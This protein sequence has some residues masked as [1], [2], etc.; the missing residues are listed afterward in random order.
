M[1]RPLYLFYILGCNYQSNPTRLGLLLLFYIGRAWTYTRIPVSLITSQL[2]PLSFLQ[3]IYYCR[4]QLWASQV[5]TKSWEDIPRKQYGIQNGDVKTVAG[6]AID[7]CKWM[8]YMN[9]PVTFN[10]QENVCILWKFVFLRWFKELKQLISYNHKRIVHHV[11][12]QALGSENLMDEVLPNFLIPWLWMYARKRERGIILKSFYKV[13]VHIETLTRSQDCTLPPP[14]SF[15]IHIQRY[16][17][18]VCIYTYRY[19]HIETPIYAYRH[20]HIEIPTCIY[21]YLYTHTDI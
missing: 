21:T 5:S 4:E 10:N 18:C 1:D 14:D 17:I 7:R 3:P 6:K 9:M 15:N 19:I 2:L 12:R 13:S 8:L 16:H 11:S 20:T